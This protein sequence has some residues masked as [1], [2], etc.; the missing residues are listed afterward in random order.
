MAQT[1]LTSGARVQVFAAVD[2]GNSEG[3][4]LHAAFGATRWEALGPVRQGVGAHFG[5]AAA[6][7]AA[8]LKLRRDHGADFMMAED[9]R[10]LSA[11]D[12]GPGPRRLA[13]L[14]A[15]AGGQRRRRAVHPSLE[16]EP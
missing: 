3:I 14:R 12:R 5:P 13:L 15:R 9:G 6:D 1:M 11:R 10:G 8:G 2:P 4:G 7:V 16:G